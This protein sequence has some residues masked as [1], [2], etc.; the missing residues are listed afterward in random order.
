MFTF[1]KILKAYFNCRK[2]KRNTFNALK[3]E[4]NF[5]SNLLKL[6]KEINN[7]TYLPGKSICFVVTYPKIREVFAADFRDRIIHHLLVSTLEPYF[8]NRFIYASFACRK[9]K[10]LQSAVSYIQKMIY[11]VTKNNTLNAYY[12]QFDIKSLFSSIDKVIL[13][14]ILLRN[15]KTNTTSQNSLQ[16]AN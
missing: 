2:N 10:G 13:K 14:Q 5:E 12:G 3:F 1:E 6:Y 4:L 8:E 9:N 15:I 7:R 16:N 11:C